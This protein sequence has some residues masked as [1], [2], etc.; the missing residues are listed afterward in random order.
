[1][2]DLFLNIALFFV[3]CLIKNFILFPIAF[4]LYN[5]LTFLFHELKLQI[6]YH[7]LF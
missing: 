3:F 5:P 7:L 1:M 4:I 6:L 2:D